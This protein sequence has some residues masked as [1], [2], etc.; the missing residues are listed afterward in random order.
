[1]GIKMNFYRFFLFTGVILIL[2]FSSLFS[3]S[4]DM[5]AVAAEEDYRWGVVAYNNGFYNKAVQ[6]LEKSLALKPENPDTLMWLG[7]SYYMS[8]MED[9]ALA[10]WDKIIDNGKA[11]ASLINLSELVKYRQLISITPEYNDA[12]TIHLDIENRVNNFKFFERP[13]SVASTKDGSGAIYVVSFATNQVLKYSANGALK[14]TFDGG[15]EGYGHPFDIYPL[16]NGNFLLSE[17]TGNIVSLCN[18]SGSRILKIGEKGISQ[19]QLLGPQFLTS[20]GKN[21]FYVTDVG[22]RKVVKYDLEGNFILEM[23]RKSADFNGLSS[24]AGITLIDEKIY[25][26]DSIKKTIEVFDESGNYLDTLVKG[27]LE[28]PEG[29]NEYNGDLLIA[30][31]SIIK[32]YNIPMDTLTVFTDRTGNTRRAINVDF[33]DNGNLLIADY[34]SNRVTVLTELSSVYGGL[35]VR[36]N[37][38]NSDSFP[39]IVV[40]FSVE[41][42]GGDPVVGLEKDN[43][44]LTEKSRSVAD[45]DLE[46]AG[47]KG[48][49]SYLT[50]LVEG[51]DK[52]KPF[53]DGLKE[54]LKVIYSA[55][56]A[57]NKTSL[58]SIGETPY[59]ISSFGDSNST[60]AIEEVT[61]LWSADWNPDIGIRLAASQMIP[62]RDKRSV[63]FLTQGDIPENS[64]NRYDIIDLAAYYRNNNISFNTVY[65]REGY[66]DRE[67]E[68]LTKSTGGKSI[69]M[70]QPEGVSSLLDD[71]QNIKSAI[72]TVSYNSSTNSDFGR[73]YIPVQLEA[74]YVNKSGRDELG[75]Y[76]PLR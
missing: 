34:E 47:Y 76:P 7:R 60:D 59:Q 55:N 15:F 13:T 36:I 27:Q 61:S 24:P 46:F 67:L 19:G 6:S 21:Y 70:F 9:A 5:K 26:A 68:Y 50:V 30:D 32:R 29:L 16:R 42:R 37:R 65:V 58:V 69:Y 75:Y 8:G 54:S 35:F 45:Y 49:D 74:I 44:I 1:M 3:Q 63:L 17:F 28:H 53:S 43:F 51:S 20:D 62:G 56:G 31:G 40:D 10:E 64:F 66:R 52:M 39:H 4:I 41:K 71:I 57:F 23:G 25:V 33:D 22:N 2:T 11:G 14:S 73:A 72:Y 12:W 18:S 48:E 38:I